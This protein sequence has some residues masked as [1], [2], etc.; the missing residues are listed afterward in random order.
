MNIVNCE[1]LFTILLY[2][3][4][5]IYI[6]IYIYISD[7]SRKVLLTIV[8]SLMENLLKALTIKLDFIVTLRFFYLFS[9]SGR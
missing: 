3:T 7:A 6:Y 5:Y 8:I 9:R 2:I 4:I 1:V